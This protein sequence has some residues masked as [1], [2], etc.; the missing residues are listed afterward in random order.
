MPLD[1]LTLAA[2]I[3]DTEACIDRLRVE[4]EPRD[5]NLLQQLEETYACLSEL[6]SWRDAFPDTTLEPL[7]P[8]AYGLVGVQ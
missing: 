1:S 4:D 5:R 3:D 7:Y 2:L 6:Q 8:T